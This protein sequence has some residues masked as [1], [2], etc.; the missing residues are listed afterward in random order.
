MDTERAGVA[1]LENAGENKTIKN[2][3]TNMEIE[4]RKSVEK[5]LLTMGLGLAVTGLKE[6]RQALNSPTPT[7]PETARQFRL[8]GS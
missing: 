4:M 3:K 7:Y 6:T 1:A 8:K 2:R 5:I